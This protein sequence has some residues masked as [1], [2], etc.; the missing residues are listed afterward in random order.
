MQGESRQQEWE[1]EFVTIPATSSSF[2]KKMATEA[3]KRIPEGWRLLPA[4]PIT[5]ISWS[6]TTAFTPTTAV[7]LIFERPYRPSIDKTER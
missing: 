5:S 4:L 2:E 7:I 3:R 6:G 1:Y